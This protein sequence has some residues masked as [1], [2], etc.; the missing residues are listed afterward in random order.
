MPS[1]TNGC[2]KN[3]VSE[4]VFDRPALANGV[5]AVKE[6]LNVFVQSTVGWPV[7][8]PPV[9]FPVGSVNERSDAYRNVDGL[10]T[11]VNNPEYTLP[12]PLTKEALPDETEALVKYTGTP[13]YTFTC[14]LKLYVAAELVFNI[15]PNPFEV[16]WNRCENDQPWLSS[17]PAA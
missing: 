2:T 13:A 12:R 15:V 5:T 10:P 4:I 9:T 7:L 6:W 1:E 16:P 11:I 8:K 14:S 3:V 17:A